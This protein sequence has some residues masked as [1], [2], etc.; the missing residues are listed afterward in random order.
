[1]IA[2]KSKRAL[3]DWYKKTA[4]QQIRPIDLKQLSSERYWEKWN[5]VSEEQIEEIATKFFARIW[6]DQGLGPEILLFDTTN[7]FTYMA[8]NTESELAQRGHNKSSKHHLR[9]VGVGVL[10]DRVKSLPLYYTT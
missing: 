8:T 9:Q 10:Q 4:I 1:M 6:E 5:R 3:Q 7:Y 2:P